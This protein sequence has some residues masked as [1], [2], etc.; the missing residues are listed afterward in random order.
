MAGLRTLMGKRRAFCAALAVAALAVFVLVRPSGPIQASTVAG[1]GDKAF[2]EYLSGTCTTCH[3]ITGQAV[4]GVP[5]ILAWPEDQF[6]A[7]MKSYRDKDR[8]NQV[9]QAIAGRL[10]D[11]EIYALAAYFGSLPLQ[12]KIQ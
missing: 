2:G 7:V 12:P 6:V 3:Q 4:G 1:K 11:E 9:M 8:E 10:T 5:P